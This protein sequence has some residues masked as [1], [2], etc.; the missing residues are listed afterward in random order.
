MGETITVTDD[1]GTEYEVD[2]NY[3]SEPRTVTFTDEGG[4]S[5]ELPY[6]AD[7]EI[8]TSTSNVGRFVVGYDCNEVGGKTGNTGSLNREN[9]ERDWERD[10]KFDEM[11]VNH[12][13]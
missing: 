7:Y 13:S 4:A 12:D 1:S 6:S 2:E 11:E 8:A 10:W 5:V 9:L 3:L